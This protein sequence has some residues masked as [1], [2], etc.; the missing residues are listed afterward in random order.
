MVIFAGK[1]DF[2]RTEINILHCC[3]AI[4]VINTILPSEHSQS[5]QSLPGPP[6]ASARERR[7]KMDGRYLPAKTGGGGGGGGSPYGAIV[8]DLFRVIAPNSA[9][10]WASNARSGR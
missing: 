1:F 6:T 4:L 10:S 3:M 9:F 7:S 2:G 8:A 5:Q